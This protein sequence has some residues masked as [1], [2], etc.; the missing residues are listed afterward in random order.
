MPNY[1]RQSSLDLDE[2][3]GNYIK[4]DSNAA[5]IRNIRT[6]ERMNSAVG[7]QEWPGSCWD[8]TDYIAYSIIARTR[9]VAAVRHGDVSARCTFA[10][11]S[12]PLSMRTRS[13]K[14]TAKS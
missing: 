13:R 1:A 12:P 14:L 5:M 3:F 2:M 7:D 9:S 6:K 4:S 8:N 10:G 11:V